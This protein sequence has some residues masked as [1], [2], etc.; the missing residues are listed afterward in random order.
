[1]K[2]EI[3]VDLMI[4]LCKKLLEMIIISRHD[5]KKLL[6]KSMCTLIKFKFKFLDLQIINVIFMLQWILDFIS[7]SFE[8]KNY[9]FND[10]VTDQS[11]IKESQI[12]EKFICNIMRLRKISTAY[13]FLTFMSNWFHMNIKKHKSILLLCSFKIVLNQWYQMREK[14]FSDLHIMIIYEDKSSEESFQSKLN[15]VFSI[16][17]RN[18]SYNFITWSLKIKYMWNQINHKIFKTVFLTSYDIWHSCILK[19]KTKVIRNK[20]KAKIKN[21]IYVSN[22]TDRFSLVL[23]NEEHHL[24]NSDIKIYL[25]VNLLNCEYHWFLTATSFINNLLISK[26]LYQYE[27]LLICISEHQRITCYFVSKNWN[28]NS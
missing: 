27:A 12:F 15:W 22:W 28:R 20:E 17:V 7:S 8:V 16:T 24:R 18:D 21:I 14:F 4:E 19:S 3:Q 25:S 1:M 2:N 10:Q 9:S 11:V 13:L 23:M 26:S 6:N 5:N